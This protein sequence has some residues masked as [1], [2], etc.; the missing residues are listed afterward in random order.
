MN[1]DEVRSRKNGILQNPEGDNNQED[2]GNVSSRITPQ[3]RYDP[4]ANGS[5]DETTQVQRKRKQHKNRKSG[6]SKRGGIKYKRGG[7]YNMLSKFLA[8][9][10]GIS[11]D[12]RGTKVVT[13]TCN[14]KESIPVEFHLPRKSND[15]LGLSEWNKRTINYLNTHGKAL[16]IFS[17]QGVINWPVK[18]NARIFESFLLE[19]NF[20]ASQEFS[21]K[22][23]KY[24][25][26][27]CRLRNSD[28][29]PSNYNIW[30][31][32]IFCFTI[33][34]KSRK[35]FRI[36]PFKFNHWN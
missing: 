16:E 4:S 18:M 19:F 36:Y 14:T 17:N 3:E 22:D 6:S 29:T 32:N 2:S 7:Y 5:G 26:H 21:R 10:P 28:L 13:Y 9:E 33:W 1:P 30:Q 31:S 25:H 20:P 35:M 27:L 15:I 12:D 24:Y 8:D 11:M 34:G 23:L